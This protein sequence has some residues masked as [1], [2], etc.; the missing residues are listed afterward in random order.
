[1]ED[2]GS[3]TTGLRDLRKM[4]DEAGLVANIRSICGL[5]PEVPAG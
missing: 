5:A 1:M 2:V 3:E 4:E